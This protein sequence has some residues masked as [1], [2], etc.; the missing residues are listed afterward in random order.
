M[1]GFSTLTQAIHF[2]KENIVLGNKTISVEIADSDAKREYGLMNRKVMPVNAGML[3]VFQA[4]QPLSFWMKDTLIPLDIGYFDKTKKLI[5]VQS[6]DV[7]STVV[8]EL[9]IYTSH[10]PAQYALEM[11]RDWFAHNHIKVGTKFK[12][13]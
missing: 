10:G 13:P 7:I 11:N 4:E 6:M 3:F 2:K 9:K 5:D 1:F 8:T 12:R